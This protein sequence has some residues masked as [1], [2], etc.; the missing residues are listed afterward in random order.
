MRIFAACR[1][2]PFMYM[3]AT[4]LREHTFEVIEVWNASQ[5]PMPEN[6]FQI[7]FRSFLK[8]L[9]SKK[10]DAAVFSL[11]LHHYAYILLCIIFSTPPILVTHAKLKRR[12]R[13]KWWYRPIKWIFSKIFIAPLV[14]LRLLRLVYIQPSIREEYGLPGYVIEPGMIESLKCTVPDL[15]FPK[16]CIVG[17]ELEREHFDKNLLNLI[18]SLKNVDI[19]GRSAKIIES[20]QSTNYEDYLTRLSSANIFLNLLDYPEC[21]YNLATLEASAAGLL[22]LSKPSDEPVIF[23]GFNGL[24]I[25]DKSSLESAIDFISKNPERCKEMMSVNSKFMANRFSAKL[26]AEKWNSV[27]LDCKKNN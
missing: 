3:Q 6:I 1:H 25:R 22:I 26:F 21:G 27:L 20:R 7:D 8:G 19:I 18:I 9:F 12:G 13:D 10:Y 2:T 23:D 14:M 5:R 24:I 17:N 4:L 15:Q 16:I 11:Q